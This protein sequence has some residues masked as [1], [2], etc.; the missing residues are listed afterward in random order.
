MNPMLTAIALQ[1]QKRM[2][3]QVSVCLASHLAHAASLERK[4]SAHKSRENHS[5]GNWQ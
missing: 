4:Q 2:A 5:K 3:G 1:A